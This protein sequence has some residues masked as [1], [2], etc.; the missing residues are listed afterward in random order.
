MTFVV[1]VIIWGQCGIEPDFLKSKAVL[2][3]FRGLAK[4]QG[5]SQIIFL[6]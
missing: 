4:L 6:T 5:L 2:S 3:L 1:S